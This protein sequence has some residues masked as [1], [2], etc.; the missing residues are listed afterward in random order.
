MFNM[1][2]IVGVLFGGV[3]GIVAMCLFQINKE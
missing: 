3:L 2:F 1:C